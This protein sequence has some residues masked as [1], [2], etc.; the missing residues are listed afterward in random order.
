[1]LDDVRDSL[2]VLKLGPLAC[3]N[4]GVDPSVRKLL[5][6]RVYKYIIAYIHAWVLIDD[7]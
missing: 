4:E 6:L 5:T 3:N 2:D 1:M 7:E